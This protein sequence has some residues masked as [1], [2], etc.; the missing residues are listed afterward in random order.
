MSFTFPAVVAKLTKLEKAKKKKKKKKN[1]ARTNSQLTFAT[2]CQIYFP[3][4]LSL[5]TPPP[6]S[7]INP[8]ASKAIIWWRNRVDGGNERRIGQVTVIIYTQ[9]N[10]M[11]ITGQVMSKVLPVSS[12]SETSAIRCPYAKINARGSDGDHAIS[13][14]GA[15]KFGQRGDIHAELTRRDIEQKRGH[16]STGGGG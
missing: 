12:G 15:G 3:P 5:A 11:V 10:I 13:G 4:P 16:A 7:D 2:P 9:P 6:L 8:F 1:K 14:E